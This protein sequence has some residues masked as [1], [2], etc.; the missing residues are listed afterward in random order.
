MMKGKYILIIALLLLG[1]NSF[2]VLGQSNFEDS[3]KNV[4]KLLQKCNIDSLRVIKGEKITYEV[5][6]FLQKDYSI[7]IVGCKELSIFI[8]NTNE[9]KVILIFY[10]ILMNEEDKKIKA[11]ANIYLMDLFSIKYRDFKKVYPENNWVN[12]IPEDYLILWKSKID[13][14]EKKYSEEINKIRMS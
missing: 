9:L 3:Y 6:S 11:I 8:Q 13:F 4:L 7:D 1:K 14:L 10:D 2:S 5:D 12:L